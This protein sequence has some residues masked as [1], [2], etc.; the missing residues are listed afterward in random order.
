M[1][2]NL[3]S[4][5]KKLI[6]VDFKWLAYKM[7]LGFWYNLTYFQEKEVIKLEWSKN[8]SCSSYVL[9]SFYIML[10]WNFL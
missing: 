1:W 8:K 6:G 9:I 10:T 2:K 5:N 7:N 4:V 3:V